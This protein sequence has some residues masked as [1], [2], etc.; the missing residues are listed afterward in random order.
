MILDTIQMIEGHM[1]PL[2]FLCHVLIFI[3][4]FYVA[5]H[6]RVLPT[7]GVT[8][9]WYIGLCSF[10]NCITIFAQLAYGAGFFL[11]YANIGSI[12]E[13]I[14]NISVAATVLIYFSNTISRDF[15]GMKKR[16]KVEEVDR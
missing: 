10:L 14:L 2:N 16:K 8:C 3:G 13:T 11:S 7:W 9:L 4:G 5:L 12:T 15:Q 1:L 6:S